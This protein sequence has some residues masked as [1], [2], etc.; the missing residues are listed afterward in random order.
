ML[1]DIFRRGR[2][3]GSRVI[4][5]AGDGLD[6]ISNGGPLGAGK[7][8]SQPGAVDQTSLPMHQTFYPTADGIEHLESQGEKASV[9]LRIMMSGNQTPRSYTSQT[10]QGGYKASSRQLNDSIKRAIEE[11]W[12]SLNSKDAAL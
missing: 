1:M 12:I 6:Y 7:V 10:L 3:I 4:K 9:P 11:G 2:G 5:E 8:L